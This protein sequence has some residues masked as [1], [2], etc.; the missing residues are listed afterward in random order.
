MKRI[1]NEELKSLALA[2]LQDVADFC[3]KNNN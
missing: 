2:I 3:E 1:N